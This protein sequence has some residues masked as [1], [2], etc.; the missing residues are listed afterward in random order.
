MKANNAVLSIEMANAYSTT[1]RRH[2]LLHFSVDLTIMGI[3]MGSIVCISLFLFLV[4][5][6]THLC[7]LSVQ[8]N[9]TLLSFLGR[10]HDSLSIKQRY[11][12]LS[13]SKSLHGR[14]NIISFKTIG[15]KFKCNFII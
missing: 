1:S 14:N 8:A 15:M 10:N 11:D 6:A 4:F 9:R 3:I 5:N 13:I 12:L 7:R 2:Y